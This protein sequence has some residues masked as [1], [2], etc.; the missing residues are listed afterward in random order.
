MTDEVLGWGMIALLATMV[1]AVA[2]LWRRRP[3]EA[4]VTAGTVRGQ[5]GLAI[6]P[7]RGHWFSTA[8]AWLLLA[9]LVIWGLSQIGSNNYAAGFFLVCAL[10]MGYVGWCRVT[11]RAVTAP[12]P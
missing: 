1:A 7:W 5:R 8:V 10:L 3:P 6:H 12:S 2:L 11:G 4:V 9:L